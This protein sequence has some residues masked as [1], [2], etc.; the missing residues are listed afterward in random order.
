MKNLKFLLLAL[1]IIATACNK[2]EKQRI[3]DVY[4]AKQ[5][6]EIGVFESYFSSPLK[7]TYK[8]SYTVNG[9][10]YSGK[11]KAYGIGQKD[12]RLIGRSFLVVYNLDNANESDINTNYSIETASELTNLKNQFKTTPPQPDWPRKNCD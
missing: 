4:A 1:L 8:Y 10:K 12:E 9:T 3:C 11:E 5:G 7:V 2:K 6:Y